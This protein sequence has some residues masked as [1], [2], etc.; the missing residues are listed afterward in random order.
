MNIAGSRLL[1]GCEREASD[2]HLGLGWESEGTG[3]RVRSR[4]KFEDGRSASQARD[5]PEIGGRPC[6]DS[7]PT[8][9]NPCLLSYITRLYRKMKLKMRVPFLTWSSTSS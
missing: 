3:Q 4:L 1:A 5:A 9:P 8:P 7:E 6:T 2:Q